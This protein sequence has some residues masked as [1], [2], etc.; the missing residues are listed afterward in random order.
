[1]GGTIKGKG[2]YGTGRRKKHRGRAA[3]LKAERLGESLERGERPLKKVSDKGTKEGSWGRGQE[4][5]A[6]RG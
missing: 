4:G 6:V 5:K 2:L 3:E 1:V